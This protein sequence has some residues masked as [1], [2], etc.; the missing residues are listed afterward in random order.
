M[1]YRSIYLVHEMQ[2]SNQQT[3]LTCFF[4]ATSTFTITNNIL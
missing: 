4:F 2:H 3:T 1:Y